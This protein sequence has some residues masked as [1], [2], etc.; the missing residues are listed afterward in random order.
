MENHLEEA[1]P[2]GYVAAFRFLRNRDE[3]RDAC[4]EA[5]TK[6]WVAKARYNPERPFYPW[7]Y[8]ILRNVCLDRIR[9]RKRSEPLE[10]EPPSEAASTEAT[11]M[12]HDQ[13][14]AINRAIAQLDGDMREVIELRHFQ[15]L[16][17]DEMATILDCPKGTIM[18]RLYRA[19]KTLNGL[20]KKDPAVERNR[21]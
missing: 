11:L 9:Q 19:R 7:F 4:Q 14:A 21:D 5:A 17:Y 8:Q 6:A 15:D 3:A 18:S 10:A 13:S 20:L 16:S 1:L 2:K 12:D